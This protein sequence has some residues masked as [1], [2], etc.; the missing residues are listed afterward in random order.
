ME[1]RT[2]PSIGDRLREFWLNTKRIIRVARRPTAQEVRLIARV[3]GIGILIV[4]AVAFLIQI[5]G[6]LVNE[7]FKPPTSSS[8]T[9]LVSMFINL[10]VQFN[11]NL[12][13][14]VL[15]LLSNPAIW[16]MVSGVI[17]LAKSKVAKV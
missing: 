14:M 4:G 10:L 9:S 7:F 15:N 11:V 1:E 3:S 13:T 5:L 8:T 6:N 12:P 2:K 16:L 17:L